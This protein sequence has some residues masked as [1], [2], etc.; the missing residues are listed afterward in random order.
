MLF[1]EDGGKPEYPE[2]KPLRAKDENHQQTQPAYD[3]ESGNRTGATLAL[4]A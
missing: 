3:T 4:H 2:K 1:F